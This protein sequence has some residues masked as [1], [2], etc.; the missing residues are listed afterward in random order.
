MENL[1]IFGLLMI[2]VL[3][4]ILQHLSNWMFR[5]SEEEDGAGVLAIVFQIFSIMLFFLVIELSRKLF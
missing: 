1:A 4:I 3:G 5:L 2:V